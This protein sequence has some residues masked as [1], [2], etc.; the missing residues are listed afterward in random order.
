MSRYT[1]EPIQSGDDYIRL[2]NL[3]P[4][5]FPDNILVTLSSKRFSRNDPPHYEALSYVWGTEEDPRSIQVVASPSG[6]F[7]SSASDLVIQGTLPIT[8]NLDCVL[9]HLR[10]VDKTRVMWVD[11]ICIDQLNHAEKGPQVG[12][13][14]DVYRL[15][16]SVIVWLGPE[17]DNSHQAMILLN[18]L[19]S[20]TE[21]DF[22]TYTWRPTPECKEPQLHVADPRLPFSNDDQRDVLS[23]ICRP[24]FERLWIR[25]EIYLA[26]PKQA[27]VVCGKQHVPWPVFR[28]ALAVLYL[29]RTARHGQD[30]G[31]TEAFR[32]RRQFL[33]GF[34]FQGTEVAWNDIRTDFGA[35][36]C[37]DA[38]DRVYAVLS[39]LEDSDKDLGIEPDYTRTVTEV[40]QDLFHRYT[41]RHKSLQMLAHCNI[42][43]GL[44][45]SWVPNWAKTSQTELPM[46]PPFPACSKLSAWFEFRGS[47][48]L[49]VAGVSVTTITKV[50]DTVLNFNQERNERR[51]E[52]EALKFVHSR[53]H[54]VDLS[55]GY[56]G[57]GTVLDAYAAAFTCGH[58]SGAYDPPI[59]P[60]ASLDECRQWV[61]QISSAENATVRELNTKSWVVG[62]LKSLGWA[63]ERVFFEGRKGLIGAGPSSMQLGDQV[64][65]FLG[66]PVALVVR[67]SGDDK[68]QVVGECYISGYSM[69]EALL[70]PLP[71]DIEGISAADDHGYYPAFRNCN[72]GVISPEDPRLS[73]LPVDLSQYRL[74]L[75][76]DPYANL[77]VEPDL[78]RQQGFDIRYF[79][80]I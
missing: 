3:H 75:E 79:D 47:Q 35:A 51:E 45:P 48:V 11:A 40:Y 78:L 52:P 42:S 17:A 80:L 60:Y 64:C 20:Q 19:G 56:A 28:T 49:R 14:G 22:Q 31:F 41:T 12:M 54:D 61:R 66:S 13:M 34:I 15:A 46:T 2:L 18:D 38:R 23:L 50:Y 53:L 10:Y 27:M 24:Y 67:P 9:R 26:N 71:Q 29:I 44:S 39:L 59:R 62:V 16:T 57:G 69:G 37:K 1:Y 36:A 72:T 7:S 55:A 68:F 33:S 74:A 21:V 77:E 30:A 5:S 32:S 63:S 25:Q 58:F 4:G 6:T 76:E 70:G 43:V 8:Q 73:S 65:V